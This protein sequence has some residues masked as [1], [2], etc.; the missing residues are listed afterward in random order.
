MVYIEFERKRVCFGFL[1]IK[2]KYKR[3]P[4]LYSKLLPNMLNYKKRKKSI[5]TKIKE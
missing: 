4:I 3:D 5:F 1:D 2:H